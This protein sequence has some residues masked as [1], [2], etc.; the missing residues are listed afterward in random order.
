MCVCM[1]G[2]GGGGGRERATLFTRPKGNIQSKRLYITCFR[3]VFALSFAELIVLICKIVLFVCSFQF[4]N[5]DTHCQYSCLLCIC[6]C[7]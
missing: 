2:G 1:S 6:V 4:V 3:L 5:L 7:V